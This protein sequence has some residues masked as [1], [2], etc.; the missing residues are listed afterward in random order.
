MADVLSHTVRVA[1]AKDRDGVISLCRMCHGEVGLFSLSD[2]KMIG[3]VDYMLSGGEGVIGVLGNDKIEGSICL[4]LSTPVYSD[5]VFLEELWN[6]VHPEYRQP[7]RAKYL[8]RYAKTCADKLVVPLFSSSV[9]SP[10]T[11]AK[12]RLYDRELEKSG[13]FYVYRP[14]AQRVAA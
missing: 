5:D 2:S 1:T 7:G 10:Q 11:E 3:I 6:F 9:V 12:H 14:N 8:V 4:K 13:A